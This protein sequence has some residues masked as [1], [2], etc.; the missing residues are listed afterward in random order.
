MGILKRILTGLPSTKED[1]DWKIAEK[2]AEIASLRAKISAYQ[3]KDMKDS[4]RR[5]IATLKGDIAR[6]R[7]HKRTLKK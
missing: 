4:A 3:S 1:C 2:Q 6:L 5:R 7:A